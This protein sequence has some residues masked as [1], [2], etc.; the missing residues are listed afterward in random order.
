MSFQGPRRIDCDEPFDIYNFKDGLLK[1]VGLTVL[2]YLS[3]RDLDVGVIRE[4]MKKVDPKTQDMAHDPEYWAYETGEQ[5]V[6]KNKKSGEGNQEGEPEMNIRFRFRIDR[7]HLVIGCAPVPD[8]DLI[9]QIFR[10]PIEGLIAVKVFHPRDIQNSG[11]RYKVVFAL[12]CGCDASQSKVSSPHFEA[13][14]SPSSGLEKMHYYEWT[15]FMD[16][17]EQALMVRNLHTFGLLDPRGPVARGFDVWVGL[18]PY[19]ERLA[20]EAQAAVVG[21]DGQEEEKKEEPSLL[22]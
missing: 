7:Y 2:H 18:L 6:R 1:K 14:F 11:N 20:R 22:D 5:I 13:K 12:D 21:G 3:A 19:Q 15:V 16:Y 10:I 8:Q 17:D 9:S 4:M